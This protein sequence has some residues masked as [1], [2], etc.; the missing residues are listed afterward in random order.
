MAKKKEKRYVSDNAQLM[1]EWDWEKNRGLNIDPT[2][3]TEGT[4]RIKP[5][6]LCK[7]CGHNWQATP[8]HRARR[9]QNCPICRYQQMISTRNNTIKTIRGTLKDNHPDISSEWHPTK[10]G[11]LSPNDVSSHSRQKVWWVCPKGHEYKASIDAR[12]GVNK[13]GCPI[14]S[15]RQ[16]LIG[17][18]DLA[19]THPQLINEW[20]FVKNCLI[21]PQNVTR[22][23]DKPIWWKCAHNHSYSSTI[24]NR[25]K[26]SGCPICANESHT[27]FPEQALLY[28]LLKLFPDACNRYKINGKVEV[29]IYVPSMRLGIEYD[30]HYYHNEKSDKEQ[31]KDNYL[32]KNGIILI[33]IK[34]GMQQKAEYRRMNS[35]VFYIHTNYD[36]KYLFLNSTLSLLISLI[37]NIF[38]MSFELDI[39][40]NRDKQDILSLFYTQKKTNSLAHKHPELLVDWDFEKNKINPELLSCGVDKV[41]YWKCHKCNSQ[42]KARVSHRAKGIGCPY[43]SGRLPIK[44]VND[45]KTVNPA[46]ANEWNY[47]KNMELIPEMFKPNSNKKV[48]WKCKS[49][50][51][52]WSAVIS[53]RNSGRGCPECAKEKRKKNQ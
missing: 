52:E 24:S 34:D 18:N 6:W 33:R 11:T 19:T 47:D 48:W 50:G 46:L 42:W 3:L 37:N 25:L 23:Y 35:N 40:I 10:N 49:C 13:T 14:C 20:D 36:Y 27:S 43:C 16:I 9:N 5:W 38:N 44:D 1:A 22:G 26:G 17:Y 4:D 7:K 28:Y 45:L 21:T 15:N 53:S 30:G 29:D 41:V 2:V 8:Y 12:A 32:A 39:D 31:L 51:H